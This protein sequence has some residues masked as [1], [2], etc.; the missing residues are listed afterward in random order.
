MDPTTTATTSDFL[1]R[2]HEGEASW[3]DY[4]KWREWDF[5]AIPNDDDQSLRHGKALTTRA[6]TTPLTAFSAAFRKAQFVKAQTGVLDQDLTNDEANR[7]NR[8]QWC[9]LGA[10]SEASLPTEYWKELLILLD[11]SQRSTLLNTASPSLSLNEHQQAPVHLQIDFCGPEMDARR[12][13]VCINTSN[14]LS[15]LTLR[16]VHQ[17]KYHDYY[18]A[19]DCCYNALLLF[20]PGIGHPNLRDDWLPTLDILFGTTSGDANNHRQ[21]TTVLLTAHSDYDASRDA[22]LLYES[23]GVQVNYT[24]N[25]FRARIEYQDPFLE[26]H[27]VRPNHCVGIVS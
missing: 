24:E 19:K 22:A 25:P 14:S 3:E 18:R 27:M 6:L 15:T 12:P 21:S 2:L 20:N 10:R 7:S 17:G 16:W 13:D 26:G 9:C 23:C 4:W 8:L 11:R 5:S 1:K